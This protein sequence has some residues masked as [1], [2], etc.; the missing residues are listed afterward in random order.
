METNTQKDE[1]TYP[2]FQHGI[3]ACWIQRPTY[4]HTKPKT[5]DGR[6]RSVFRKT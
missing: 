5:S 6:Q 2:K 3:R 1:E 4:T